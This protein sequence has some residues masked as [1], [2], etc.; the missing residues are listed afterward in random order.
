MQQ[1]SATEGEGNAKRLVD[2]SD[3]NNLP[4][5]REQIQAI[6]DKTGQSWRAIDEAAGIYGQRK[7]ERFV[8]NRRFYRDP[9]DLEKIRVWVKS[10]SRKPNLSEL[11]YALKG[12]VAV[13]YKDVLRVWKAYAGSWICIAH[14]QE[15]GMFHCMNLW[16]MTAPQDHNADDF[17]LPKF[18]LEIGSDPHLDAGEPPIT[19]II[20][21]YV[22]LR[23]EVLYL[24]GQTK[25]VPEGR[26]ALLA[27]RDKPDR[28]PRDLMDGTA[29]LPPLDRGKETIPPMCLAA[30]RLQPDK[31]GPASGFLTQHDIGKAVPDLENVLR[32]LDQVNARIAGQIP[33]RGIN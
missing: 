7:T 12:A 10:N 6:K 26:L 9:G 17:P 4:A 1:P 13:D 15:A 28:H 18:R 14:S 16:F 30:K 22:Q 31:A 27:F 29:L 23:D 8:T 11:T 19:H 21:G 24:V 3:N 2:Y 25:W 5:L 33:T 20:E 32:R